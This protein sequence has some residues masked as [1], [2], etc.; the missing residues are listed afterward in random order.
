MHLT[1]FTAVLFATLSYTAPNSDPIAAGKATEL[2]ERN[3]PG[4]GP[5][6]LCPAGYFCV[7][8][9]SATKVREG[10][11]TV[12]GIVS[13]ILYN[14]WIDLL[15]LITPWS[16][17]ALQSWYIKIVGLLD[18]ASWS[19]SFGVVDECLRTACF[20]MDCLLMYAYELFAYG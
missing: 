16:F 19:F 15:P 1:L 20:L 13:R 3:C 12:D 5:G 4:G 6:N 7:S 8:L 10:A 14:V 17:D 18:G 2:W 9:L 11:D